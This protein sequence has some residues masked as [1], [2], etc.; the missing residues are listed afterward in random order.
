[1]LSTQLGNILKKFD[2]GIVK[3]KKKFIKQFFEKCGICT[4]GPN[5]MQKL[6]QKQLNAS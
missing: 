3:F 2:L 6:W 4:N 1:M 5:D